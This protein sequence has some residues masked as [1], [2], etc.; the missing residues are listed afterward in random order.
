MS[1]IDSQLRDIVQ[2]FAMLLL[3]TVV[4]IASHVTG[5]HGQL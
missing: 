1:E 2:S 5:P 4:I 3:T